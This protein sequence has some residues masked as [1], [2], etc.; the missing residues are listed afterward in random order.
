MKSIST[1]LYLFSLIGL[2]ACQ[3]EVTFE[4]PDN[5]AEDPIIDGT[6]VSIASVRDS[7]LQAASSGASSYQFE[8]TNTYIEGYVISSDEAGNFFEELILQQS[9][10]NPEG[11]IKILIDVN[12][13]FTKYDLGRKVYV[14]LDG[15]TVGLDSGVLSLGISGDSN[16]QKISAS[17]ESLFLYRSS[18]VASLVPVEKTIGQLD[19]NDVNTL[20]QL[21]HAQFTESQIGLTFASEPDDEFDGDRLIES[22]SLDGGA[23]LFQTSTFS[24]F[25][26]L[27]LPNGS[28]RLTAI[29]S[30]N[31]FG[32]TYS[33]AIRDPSD[34]S[35]DS[36]E[37]CIPKPLDPNLMPTTTFAA[38]RSRYEQAGGYAPFS[39]EEDLLIIEGYVVSSDEAGN[40]F[41]EL[42]I[43]NTYDVKDLGPNNPRMGLRILI[44]KTD[45]YQ[46]F[47]VGRKV[48]VKLNGLAV[49]LESGV[50]SLG[51]QNVSQ[52]E[53]IPEQSLSNFVVGGQE[54]EEIIPLRTTVSSLDEDDLNTLVELE[55]MQFTRDEIGFTYAGEPID[56]FDGERTLESCENTGDIR[57]FTSTFADFKSQLLDPDVGIIKAL[58]TSDFS[59]SENILVIRNLED[60]NF[61]Q[62]RCDPPLVDCGIAAQTG[63]MTVF[64]DFFETQEVGEP[65]A[66]NGWTN[67]AEAGSQL[68]EAYSDTGSNASLG[69]SARIGS[70][71]SGDDQT[72][73]WLISPLLNFDSL[74]GETF[75]FKTSNSFADGSELEVF[76][77]QD[78]NGTVQDITTATW[79]ELSLATIV[80]DNTFFG[81]W[82]PSG[83][84]RLDCIEG[85]GYIGFR[86]QGSGDEGFDGTYELDEIEVRAN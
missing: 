40:F 28:G 75:T 43:Q 16:L 82:V 13:L 25:K 30:K 35:F 44:D 61:N 72:I 33:L 60:I 37:R 3:P 2:L 6:M 73:G 39:L 4:V 41:D 80:S 11:G 17:Q 48:Y 42:F 55:L 36:E 76:Y 31:F 47:A 9:P 51:L 66:G 65:I 74:S 29:F 71:M 54:T 64:S 46:S 23:L 1:F 24:D 20:I 79:S 49:T 7:Y 83:I 15:L 53:K 5:T 45:S 78:W 27:P 50:L 38:V 77:S 63:N 69:I 34:I 12:P 22:C 8:N 14:A 58:Y 67:F 21:P 86:Y 59:G 84:I 57:L 10:E 85:S 19:E 26:A 56:N 52:I 68:W 70:F 18:E 62:E 32:D 81:D